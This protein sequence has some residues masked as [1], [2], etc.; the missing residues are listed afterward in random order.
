MSQIRFP[1]LREYDL[2][3]DWERDRIL[4]IGKG[5]CVKVVFA[6]VDNEKLEIFPRARKK[7]DEEELAAIAEAKKAADEWMLHMNGDYWGSAL[8]ALIT[9]DSYV[10]H[11]LVAL[12]R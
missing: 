5:K 1:A 6:T 12:S 2:K 9:F 8:S 4:L 11:H 10:L 3:V 7:A